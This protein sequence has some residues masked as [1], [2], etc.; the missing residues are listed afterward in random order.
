MCG[1]YKLARRK[2]WIEEYFDIDPWQ[3]DWIPRYNIAP[4]QPV[5]LI[6]QN[7]V[8][9]VRE[10]SLARW[11]LIPSWAKDPSIGSKTINARS[12]TVMTT[13]SFRNLFQSQRCLIPADGFYEWKTHGKSKQPYCFQVGD[14]EIFAFAGLWDKWTDPNGKVIETCTILTTS[15]N[16]LLSNIHDR[17][18]VIL[19]QQHYDSW[20]NSTARDTDSLKKLLV[21]YAGPMR[22]YAVSA[23]VNQALNDDAG[24]SEPIRIEPAPEGELFR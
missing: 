16:V 22:G 7:P 5:P 4:T 14:G 24:C 2:P 6:R 15:P 19:P 10:I 12:E 8:N 18:P 1:R 21:P 9:R 20:L 3:E 23:R 13:V 17:M 11:G